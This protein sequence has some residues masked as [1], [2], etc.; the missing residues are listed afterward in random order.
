ME[1]TE[2]IE[3]AKNRL[4]QEGS[5][6]LSVRIH[7]RAKQTAFKELLEDGSIKIAIKSAPEDGRANQE[8]I[9]FL[10]EIFEIPPSQI[11]ILSGFA[12]R[13]KMIRI[14]SKK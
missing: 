11:E 10:S 5:V 13:M 14:T 4:H 3:S 12:A 7:P 9:K 6:V 8:L 1:L 2:F